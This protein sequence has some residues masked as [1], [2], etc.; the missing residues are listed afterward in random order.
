MMDAK[1]LPDFDFKR[2]TR[3]VAGKRWCNANQP[4]HAVKS[5]FSIQNLIS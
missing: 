5:P 2:M 3:L 1:M 4:T